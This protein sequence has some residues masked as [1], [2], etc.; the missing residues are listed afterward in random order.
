MFLRLFAITVFLLA[1]TTSSTNAGDFAKHYVPTNPPK[2]V[3]LFQ[4]Q[5][6]QGVMRDLKEYKGRFILLN[7]WATWCSPCVKE[8]PALNNLQEQ[9]DYRLLNVIALNEDRNGPAAA[10]AFYATHSLKRLPVFTDPSG[11][12]PFILLAPGLPVSILINPQ[13]MEIGRVLGEADWAAPDS[14]GF[15]KEI[16]KF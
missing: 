11:R 12:A 9:F 15:L 14:I 8:M 1:L 2:P 16:I 3:P 6:G 7:L 13:G 4:F 10:Q 5:D